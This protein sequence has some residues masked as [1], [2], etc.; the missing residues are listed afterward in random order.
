M[1]G[2]LMFGMAFGI[3]FVVLSIAYAVV[4]LNRCVME[5]K[6]RK[7][8]QK[9]MEENQELKGMLIYFIEERGENTATVKLLHGDDEV[10]EI[11]FTSEEKI[12]SDLYAGMRNCI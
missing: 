2:W 11:S 6:L 10:A 9:V 12:S 4:W 1:L 5:E 7:A 3:G 8:K